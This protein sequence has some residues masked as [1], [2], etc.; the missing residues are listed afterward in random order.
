MGLTANKLRS[1]EKAI[2]KKYQPKSPVPT[3]EIPDNWADFAAMCDVRSAG[4]IV[5]FEAYDYQ[6]Q[7]VSLMQER[8]VIVAKTR[9]MGVSETVCNFLLW[10]A[11]RNPGY[12]ALVISKTQVDTSLLSRRVQRML[13]SIGLKT[14]TENLQHIQLLDGGQ[15]IFRNSSPEAARGLES[16]SDILFD[17]FAFVPDIKAIFTAAQPC[18]TMLGNEARTYIISSPNGRTGFFWDLLNEGQSFNVEDLAKDISKGISEPFQNWIDN[19]GWGKILLH[20]RAHPIYGKNPDFLAEIKERQK[21]TE[22]SL[23]QEYNLNFGE[24]ET[25]YF[26]QDT[27]QSCVA[28]F[29]ETYNKESVYTAGLDTSGSGEDYCVLTITENN[30]VENRTFVPYRKRGQSAEVNLYNI[31]EILKTYRPKLTAI[32][33]N[34]HGQIYLEQ[35][36]RMLPYLRFKTIKTTSDSKPIM[37]NRL[38]F[39]LEKQLL[40]YSKKSPLITE[41]LNFRKSGGKLQAASGAHDDCVM[42]LAFNVVAMGELNYI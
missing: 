31:C 10:R 35:L 15:I 25:A 30:G 20:W 39:V 16:V 14:K 36:S 13:T 22:E 24:V 27:V 1:L 8:S 32:E 17:E 38:S 19:S 42:S 28:E 26:P 41:L 23:Q 40:K 12:M 34:S 29:D 11:A 4:N 33:V 7:L 3:I 2:R 5:K 6:K 21:L 18:Q 37:I 9:Q